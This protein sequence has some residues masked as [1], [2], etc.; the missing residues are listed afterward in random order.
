MGK[1]VPFAIVSSTGTEAP[2]DDL[3]TLADQQLNLRLA[4]RGGPAR[5]QRVPLH[6]LVQTPLRLRY[7]GDRKRPEVGRRRALQL[8]PVGERDL[9]REK[10]AR[11]KGRRVPPVGNRDRKSTRLNSSH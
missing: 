11:R 2:S 5:R 3:V 7:R 6:R 10:R 9:R 4:Q 8:E 1:H